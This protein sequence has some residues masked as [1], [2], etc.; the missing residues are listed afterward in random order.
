MIMADIKL[1][2]DEMN[3]LT[4][5]ATYRNFLMIDKI[6][7][8]TKLRIHLI[9]KILDKFKRLRLVLISSLKRMKKPHELV[10]EYSTKGMMPSDIYKVIEKEYR[11][12]TKG[13]SYFNLIKGGK[14]K[15]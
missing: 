12:T 4:I 5:L 11:L 8:Y 13:L 2:V 15:E 3:V 10:K 14:T 9:K 6:A 7:Y 1:T